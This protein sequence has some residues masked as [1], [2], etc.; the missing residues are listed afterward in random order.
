[1]IDERLSLHGLIVDESYANQ[2]EKLETRRPAL[3]VCRAM[4]SGVWVAGTQKEK[5][6]VCT[7]TIHGVVNSYD[8]YE[9]LENVDGAARISWVLWNR[10]MQPHLGAVYVDKMLVARH[11]DKRKPRYTHYIG[12]LSSIENFGTIVYVNEVSIASFTKS[13]E[14]EKRVYFFLFDSV[15]A[16]VQTHCQYQKIKLQ[17]VKLR[18]YE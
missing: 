14:K 3:Y 5:E 8:R 12:T 17:Q 10:F 9:L 15:L 6:R 4:H 13:F 16:K 7:V 2:A 11:E 1:M 18:K